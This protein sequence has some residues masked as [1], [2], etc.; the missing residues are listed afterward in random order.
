MGTLKV[1]RVHQPINMLRDFKIVVDSNPVGGVANGEVA[2]FPLAP[3]SHEVTAKI[4]WCRSP[5]VTVSVEAGRTVELEVG[6]NAS[7]WGSLGLL[8]STFFNPSGY[9]Y[10]RAPQP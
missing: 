10:L 5:P 9:L 6:C 1:R 4:D 2:E 8:L 3:G 7:P